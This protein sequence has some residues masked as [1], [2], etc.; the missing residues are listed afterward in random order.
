[1][2]KLIVGLAFVTVS[3][4]ATDVSQ[5]KILGIG[6][7][8]KY[9]DIKKKL[10]CNNFE[11]DTEWCQV[12]QS[13]L[14]IKT[15]SKQAHCKKQDDIKTE[16]IS[17]FIDGNNKVKKVLRTIVFEISPNDEK[18]IGDILKIYGESSAS[19]FLNDEW[20]NT[21]YCWGNCQKNKHWNLTDISGK[22]L[23][24]K[25][26]LNGA[27]KFVLDFTLYDSEAGQL[28]LEN[29]SKECL[30]QL[31]LKNKSQKDKASSINL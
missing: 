27:G 3:L 4:F 9:E 29:N 21:A 28:D 20:K 7:G 10:P 19:S 13:N 25:T 22:G 14:S 23:I 18:I 26:M 1:M 31:N 30:R 2:K 15:N 6:L 12:N 11:Y 17:I 8:D 5:M 24:V 16:S